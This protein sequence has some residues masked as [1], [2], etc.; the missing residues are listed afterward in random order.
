VVSQIIERWQNP[1]TRSDGITI[2]CFRDG[3]WL[4]EFNRGQ[5]ELL[6]RP[7]AT[8]ALLF[9][10]TGRIEVHVLLL[11]VPPYVTWV[12]DENVRTD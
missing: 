2:E 8:G 5:A 4:T 12:G 11:L 7:S 9:P 10:A 6:I 1:I 3:Q